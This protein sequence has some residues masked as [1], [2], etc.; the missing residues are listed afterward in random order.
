[1]TSSLSNPCLLLPDNG[2]VPR[3]TTAR[4]RRGCKRLSEIRFSQRPYTVQYRRD[5]EV[6]Q[7][8][9]QPPPKL[10]EALPTDIVEIKNSAST[11]WREGESYEVKH[12]NWKHPNVL[13]IKNDDGETTFVNYHDIALKK[14]VA[15]RGDTADVQSDPQANR[16]LQWP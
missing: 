12:I 1:M 11:H 2:I 15:P 5:G 13:Q 4:P 16:Y 14:K 6:R 10:H 7:Y 8:R 3:P 9:R